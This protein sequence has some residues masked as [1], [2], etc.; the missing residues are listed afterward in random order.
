MKTNRGLQSLKSISA[1]MR[2]HAL[3][4]TLSHTSNAYLLVYD[5]PILFP[6]LLPVYIL[7][8]VITVPVQSRIALRIHKISW[9]WVL[10]GVLL[11][12]RLTFLS[13]DFSHLSYDT[14]NSSQGINPITLPETTPAKVG[15][16]GRHEALKYQFSFVYVIGLWIRWY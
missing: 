8:T 16:D 3:L 5:T 11:L 12:R 7:V 2:F 1:F 10:V 14:H 4:C 15:S 9:I 13:E 6:I